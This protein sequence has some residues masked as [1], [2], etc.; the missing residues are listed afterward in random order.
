MG[1]HHPKP[2]SQL[3][4]QRTSPV[5]EPERSLVAEAEATPAPILSGPHGERIGARAARAKKKPN[6]S[7]TAALPGRQASPSPPPAVAASKPTFQ[8]RRKDK[9]GKEKKVAKER[10]ASSSVDRD[11]GR[12][13]S[14][15]AVE[16]A[17]A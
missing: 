8:F 3:E 17:L 13:Q 12:R 15:G 16:Q 11:A 14:A 9:D 10:N 4:E 2:A 1:R 5:P 7:T 6:K